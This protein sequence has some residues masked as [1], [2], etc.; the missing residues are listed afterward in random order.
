MLVQLG[1]IVRWNGLRCLSAQ[2]AYYTSFVL[3]SPYV[4]FAKDGS[5][6]TV[7]SVICQENPTVEQMPLL[8]ASTDEAFFSAFH[9]HLI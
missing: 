2:E 1:S 7:L 3:C 4:I 5:E 8:D 6:M 9:L